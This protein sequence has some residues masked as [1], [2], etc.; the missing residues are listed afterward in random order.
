MDDI[1]PYATFEL[2]DCK[3]SHYEVM[4]CTKVMKIFTLSLSVSLES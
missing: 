1:Y 3:D 4:D 2:R